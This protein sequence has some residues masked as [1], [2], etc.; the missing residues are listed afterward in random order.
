MSSASSFKDSHHGAEERAERLA[1]LSG[2]MALARLTHQ[3][4]ELEFKKHE[5]DKLIKPSFAS[6]TCIMYGLSRYVAF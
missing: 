1:H 6:I 2:A 5:Q 3:V 4:K